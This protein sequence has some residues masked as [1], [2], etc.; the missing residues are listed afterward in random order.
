MRYFPDRQYRFPVSN[1]AVASSFIINPEQIT[2]A[3]KASD[4]RI[5]ALEAE[6][7]VRYNK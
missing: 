2:P 1:E 3:L 7:G 5:K 6:V 4:E